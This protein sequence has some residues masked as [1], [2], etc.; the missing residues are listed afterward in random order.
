MRGRVQ[1]DIVAHRGDPVHA[2]ENTLASF[3]AAADRGAKVVE[4]DLRRT[5][6]G[7]WVAF[8]DAHF[9]RM[10]GRRGRV[11]RSRWADLRA[12]DVGGE[13]I[14][15]LELLL[16]WCRRRKVRLF[17]DMKVSGQEQELFRVLR[18]LRGLGRVAGGAGNPAALDRWRRLLKGRTAL[19]WVTGFRAPVTVN[20][21]RIA[22]GLRLSGLVVY[23]RW[24]TRAS[25][26]RARSA[27]LKLYVWTVRSPDELK[28]FAQLGVDGIM[29]EGWPHPSI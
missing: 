10:A 23:K 14:P 26:L 28:R 4:T 11:A 19:F 9:K 3:R 22:R 2:P 12:L 18:R 24:A 17:L 20:R 29:S 7:V 5:A 6:D 21:V 13:P 27:G 16:D 1:L 8:H 15:R 25:L